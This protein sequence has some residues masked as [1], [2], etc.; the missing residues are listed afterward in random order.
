MC[1]FTFARAPSFACSLCNDMTLLF[2]T[3]NNSHK[4]ALHYIESSDVGKAHRR[5]SWRCGV[6]HH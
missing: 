4:G 3:M 1:D 6:L 2:G 5:G